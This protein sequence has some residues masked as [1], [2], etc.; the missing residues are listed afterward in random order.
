MRTLSV[1]GRAMYR[2]IVCHGGSLRGLGVW[3][4]T[5]RFANFSTAERAGERMAIA[6]RRIVGG[7]PTFQIVTEFDTRASRDG[8]AR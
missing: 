8:G 5:R 7:S 3:G 1:P 2:A 6:C 4:E